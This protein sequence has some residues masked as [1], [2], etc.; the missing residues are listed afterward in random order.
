MVPWSR[1][2]VTAMPYREKQKHNRDNRIFPMFYRSANTLR[3]K[4]FAFADKHLTDGTGMYMRIGNC[5]LIES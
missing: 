4:T 5:H 2:G 1:C 3:A